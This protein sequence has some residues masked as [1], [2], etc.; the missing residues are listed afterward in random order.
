MTDVETMTGN[1]G[2]WVLENVMTDEAQANV[3]DLAW[4]PGS[5]TTPGYKVSHANKVVSGKGHSLVHRVQPNWS[6]NV[7]HSSD[8]YTLTSY[9]ADCQALANIMKDWCHVWIIGNEVNID[10][11]NLR[12]GGSSYNTQWQPTPAQYAAAYVECRDKIHLVTPTTN[13]NTQLVLMQP[14]SPGNIISGVR[15]MDGNEFLWRQIE[16]V[17]DK[18][19]IDGF[20]LHAYAGGGDFLREDFMD[21]LREQ[22]MIID[23]WGLGD[24]PV[25]VGEWDHHMPNSTEVQNGARF[26]HRALASL[27]AWNTG[28]GGEW[29]GLSNHNIVSA[30][31]FVYP[32]GV[33][34]DAFSL[35]ANKNA[36]GTEEID[37]WHAFQYACGFNYAKGANGGGPAVPPSAFWWGDTFDGSSLDQAAPLPDW[38][39]ENIN[40]GST[41]LS[42]TGEVRLVAAG[43][44][45][46]GSIR[47]AGYAYDNFRL[48]TDIVFTDAGRRASDEA[49]FDLRIREGSLGYSLTFYSS[50]STVRTNQVYLRRTNNWGETLKSQAI[51]G[52]INSGDSFRVS[53]VASGATITYRVTRN[54]SGPVVLDWTGANMV[55]DAGQKT[56]TIR[57]ASYNLR[58]A[59]IADFKLGGPLWNGAAAQVA[60]WS[61]Y[62]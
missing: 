34:W 28:T 56:G 3:W 33:G 37:P 47:T 45:Q 2:I 52:G 62:R 26:L 18:S 25:F 29:P 5:K 14:V 1:R 50:G 9:G 59:C 8:P 38:K 48:E 22:L 42:G 16:A 17:T 11:E 57:M 24:R 61:I 21:S 55:T 60:D 51:S 4:V 35:F 31:W 46:G 20:C 58:E 7:P 15:Y 12:W 13:P 36:S 32:G 49:N 44:Y 53:V 19:K 27:N 54:P 6:R 40:G 39:V 10:G 41:V 23:S 43:N 30:A